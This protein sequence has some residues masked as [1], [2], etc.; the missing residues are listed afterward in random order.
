MS[1]PLVERQSAAGPASPGSGSSVCP[2]LDAACVTHVLRFVAPVDFKAC[3]LVSRLW[4]ECSLDTSLPFWRVLNWENFALLNDNRPG[5]RPRP[6]CA[7][8][9]LKAY[10]RLKGVLEMLDLDRL[11]TCRLAQLRPE[12]EPIMFHCEACLVTLAHLLFS[13]GAPR[14]QMLRLPGSP[15]VTFTNRPPDAR[16]SFFH[17][18]LHDSDF[19]AH[20]GHPNALPQLR[21]LWMPYARANVGLRGACF[22][23]IFEV[24]PLLVELYPPHIGNLTVAALQQLAGRP[25]LRVNVLDR[26]PLPAQVDVICGI[27]RA[28]L[29]RGLTSFCKAPP[30]QR[31]ITE[32]WYTNEPP[33][34]GCHTTQLGGHPDMLNCVNGCHAAHSLY[35]VDGGTGAV[36]LYGWRYGIAVGDGT[37]PR[38]SG[39]GGPL[40]GRPPLALVV[41]CGA[42]ETR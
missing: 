8:D 6:F 9:A 16:P 15:D 3:L 13:A 7:C 22:T 39:W 40:V 29:W 4:Y 1:A 24:A 30:T 18:A 19:V 27:C 23:H 5:V 12:S 14:L 26:E 34:E 38:A 2:A 11:H 41:P 33:S 20:P 32:E 17:E 31:H 10:Q 36:E 35:L 37:G 21:T 42:V 25:A 28:P